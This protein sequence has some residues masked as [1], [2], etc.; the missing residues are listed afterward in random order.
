MLELCNLARLY[1]TLGKTTN[2][3]V[4]VLEHTIIVYIFHL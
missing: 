3:K 4:A 2:G 1:A